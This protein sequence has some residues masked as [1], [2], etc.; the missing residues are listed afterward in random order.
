LISEDVRDFE[1]VEGRSDVV[2]R[3]V[4]VP[5][6]ASRLPEPPSDDLQPATNTVEAITTA[7]AA[8]TA[9]PTLEKLWR[10][11][12][13]IDNTTKGTQRGEEKPEGAGPQRVTPRNA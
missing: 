9:Q 1:A 13:V 10:F 3:S 5:V 12:C 4:R 11:G 8:T 7:A 6:R 2:V